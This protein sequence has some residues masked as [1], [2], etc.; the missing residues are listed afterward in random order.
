MNLNTNATNTMEFF[1]NCN[2]SSLATYTVPLD[3][4]KAA[5][6]YRRLGFS[7]SNATIG[8]TY[9]GRLEQ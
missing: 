4:I 5:H 7:A 1:I 2:N 3:K 6:L 8:C 9:L